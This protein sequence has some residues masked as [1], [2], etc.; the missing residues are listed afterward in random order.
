MLQVGD[1][2]D[3]EGLELEETQEI[4]E[5]EEFGNEELEE[6]EP[7]F[8][9]EL[10]EGEEELDCEQDPLDVLDPLEPFDA[11]CS[12]HF[13]LFLSSSVF[14][15]VPRI[16]DASFGQRSTDQEAELEGAEDANAKC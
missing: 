6:F 1:D 9:P 7:P 2:F 15:L 11:S 13:S 3:L 5:S 12:Q 14:F 4:E 10:E 8:D 16:L